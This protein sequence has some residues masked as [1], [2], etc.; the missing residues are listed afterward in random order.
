MHISHARVI[1]YFDSLLLSFEHANWRQRPE[2]F[3]LEGTHVGR[4]IGQNSG[5][6]EVTLPASVMR[7]QVCMCAQLCIVCKGCSNVGISV[8]IY[9]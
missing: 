6:K 1:R 9:T 5:L 4:Y 2:G 3:L 8:Y 7:T